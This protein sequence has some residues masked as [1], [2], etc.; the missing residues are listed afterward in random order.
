[1][2]YNDIQRRSFNTYGDYIAQGLT[3]A[4]TLGGFSAQ[5]IT[6]NTERL[7]TPVPDDITLDNISYPDTA[8]YL[9][10]ASTSPQDNPAGTGAASV[11]IDL[12]DENHNPVRD[13]VILDGTTPVKTSVKA[14]RYNGMLVAGWGALNVK[15]RNRR[16]SIGDIYLGSDDNFTAGVADNPMCAING[17][18]A[19]ED[20]KC[21]SNREAMY[22]V[23]ADKNLVFSEYT[24]NSESAKEVRVNLWFRIYGEDFFRKIPPAVLTE[25]SNLVVLSGSIGLPP[26]TDIMATAINTKGNNTFVSINLIGRLFKA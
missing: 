25:G 15:V 2:N 3:P 8:D 21:L 9:Y 18:N 13:L 14:F 26:R 6:R 20:L 17:A 5:G 22:T 24:F 10:V 23:P 4:V 19:S 16:F 11:L 1:M 12:L 7:I